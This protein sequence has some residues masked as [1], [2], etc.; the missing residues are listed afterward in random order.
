[1]RL[2]ERRIVLIRAATPEAAWRA[3]VRHAKDETW[4]GRPRAGTF[5]HNEFIGVEELM[6]LGGE[7]EENEVW[8]EFVPMLRP[9]ER[10]ARLIPRKSRLR[11]FE[12]GT[13]R[14]YG[15]KI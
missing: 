4:T 5:V 8:W 12:R 14:R 7:A 2:V 11:A 1:M 10:R 13:L 15:P 6:E 9:M 3:A